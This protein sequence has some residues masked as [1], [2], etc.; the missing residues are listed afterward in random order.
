[1]LFQC[2]EQA[3]VAEPTCDLGAEMGAAGIRA[4]G[5]PPWLQTEFE[6]SP[7]NRNPHPLKKTTTNEELNG[8][9]STLSLSDGDG[10]G[11]RRG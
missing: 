6:A 1:M 4:Q 11:R 5:H 8:Q 3:D 9:G 2:S 7:G 10:R